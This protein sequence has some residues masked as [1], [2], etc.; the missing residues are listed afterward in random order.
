M[1]IDFETTMNEDD[2]K[3]ALLNPKEERMAREMQAEPDLRVEGLDRSLWSQ[4]F[5]LFGGAR[6]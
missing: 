2:F 4:V 1:K 3:R 6:R 5:S